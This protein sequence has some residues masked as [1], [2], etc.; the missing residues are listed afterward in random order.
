MT[1]K[2]PEKKSVKPAEMKA[3][4]KVKGTPEQVKGTISKLIK[5]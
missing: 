4:I 5:K 2:K 3:K 1:T